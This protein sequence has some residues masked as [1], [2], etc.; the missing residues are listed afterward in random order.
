MRRTQDSGVD[1]LTWCSGSCPR[2]AVSAQGTGPVSGVRIR[3]QRCRRR[4]FAS[5]HAITGRARDIQHPR[6]PAHVFA[7]A[8]DRPDPDDTCRT[9]TS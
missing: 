5:D 6:V 8:T 2:T 1:V 4:Q 7:R 3:A 9:Q